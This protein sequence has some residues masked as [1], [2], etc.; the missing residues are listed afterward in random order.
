MSTLTKETTSPNALAPIVR[1]LDNPLRQSLEMIP[2][3][4]GKR[5]EHI[6]S[7]TYQG[8]LQYA[9]CAAIGH[10]YF[11]ARYSYFQ[12]SVVPHFKKLYKMQSKE[13]QAVDFDRAER[14][15]LI[16]PSAF[17]RFGRFLKRIDRAIY[18]ASF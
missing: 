7:M 13:Q 4:A 3:T 10:P 8:L 5:G 14:L 1:D 17:R 9:E 11:D 15:G 2:M 12:N 16:K 6:E 18:N